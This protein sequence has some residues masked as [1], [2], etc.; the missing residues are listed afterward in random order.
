[1]EPVRTSDV[2]LPSEV[3]RG[4][5][6]SR[7]R[8]AGTRGRLPPHGPKARSAA[9]RSPTTF[10]TAGLRGSIHTLAAAVGA[11][12]L[13]LACAAGE[14]VTLPEIDT[15]GSPDGIVDLPEDVPE[16]F[17]QYFVKYTYF[18]APNGKRIHFLAQDG[19][20]VDQIQHG[21]NV[22]EHLLADFPGSAYGNDKSGIA[23][24]MADRK[25]T[26]VFFNTEDDLDRA[27]REGLGRAVDLSM[28]DLRA[29]E[30]PAVGDADYM[31]HVT[32]DA[33][34]EEIWHLVHDYGIKPV[35]PEMI[36]EMRQA[37]DQAAEKGWKGWPDD[38]PEEH[39]NEYMGVLIDN[40]YDLWTVPPTLY[41]ARP[42]EPGDIPD[43]YS[44]FDRYFAGSRASLA[45]K[46]PA[47]LAL[48]GKFVPPHLTYTPELPLDF[49]GTFSMEFDPDVRYTAKSQHL[50]NARLTGE[51]GANLRGNDGVNVLTGNAGANQLQGQG[52][53]D[54]LDGGGGDDTAIFRGPAA[55]YEVRSEGA[56]TTIV[57]SVADRDGTDVLLGIEFLE[58]S[59]ETVPVGQ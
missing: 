36:A 6:K 35:L 58:F 40:Y 44:H 9:G 23:N 53:D 13:A 27:F 14:V 4:K 22:L 45:A 30:S 18:T 1:M 12:L 26:M 34:Y 24:A 16:V 42:I 2:Q 25:A 20:T 50:R 5:E 8:F 19:W 41:E 43:G 11:C 56:S 49:E 51:R 7:G 37:N 33:A 46:D 31:G 38:E 52:G 47:G 59:D 21:R 57:D 48:V 17:H 29:N 54:R 39:P 3:A 15:S 55:D 32:R 10:R 28:Q